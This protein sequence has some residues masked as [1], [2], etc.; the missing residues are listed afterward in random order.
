MAFP[1]QQCLGERATMQHYSTS[2]ILFNVKADGT[3]H[4]YRWLIILE[5]DIITVFI[6]VGNMHF[7]FTL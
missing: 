4:T 1:W 2:S 6:E 5:G 3:I 7:H